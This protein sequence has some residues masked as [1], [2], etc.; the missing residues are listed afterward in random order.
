MGR[1]ACARRE[2]FGFCDRRTI[3][4]GTLAGAARACAG[5]LEFF[6]GAIGGVYIGVEG[7]GQSACPC[8]RGQSARPRKHSALGG[9]AGLPPPLPLRRVQQVYSLLRRVWQA[10]VRAGSSLPD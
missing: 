1:I 7:G 4:F 10:V 3:G 2:G 5:R 9:Y 6:S 8:K